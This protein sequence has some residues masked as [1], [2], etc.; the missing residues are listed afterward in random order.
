MAEA[1][2]KR[3]IQQLVFG[4]DTATT[5]SIEEDF[6]KEDERR[7]SKGMPSAYVTVFEGWFPARL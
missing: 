6:D 1:A 7:F 2:P 4:G 3:L 5:D